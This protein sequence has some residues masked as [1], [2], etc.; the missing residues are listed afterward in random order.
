M[1]DCF[2]SLLNTTAQA[3][4]RGLFGSA[5]RTSTANLRRGEQPGE[6][7]SADA[8]GIEAIL[9]LCEAERAG[10]YRIGFVCVAGPRPDKPR[11]N[12]PSGYE[13]GGNPGGSY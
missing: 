1:G 5:I 11:P 9:V 4:A 13:P 6:L 10:L 3:S 7:A 2:F 12:L 8:N